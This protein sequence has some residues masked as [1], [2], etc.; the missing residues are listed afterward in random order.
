[1][2]NSASVARH[3]VAAAATE[4]RATEGLPKSLNHLD[5]LSTSAKVY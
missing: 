5:N 4:W 2:F 1:M 3:S